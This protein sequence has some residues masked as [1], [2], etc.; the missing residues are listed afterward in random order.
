MEDEEDEGGEAAAGKQDI[1]MKIHTN[2]KAASLHQG[3]NAVC[4]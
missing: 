4:K 1:S 3:S 2:E